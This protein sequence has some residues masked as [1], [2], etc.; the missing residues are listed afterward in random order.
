METNPVAHYHE[1]RTFYDHIEAR[2]EAT[3]EA[4]RDADRDRRHD[5]LCKAVAFAGISAQTAVSKHER[6]YCNAIELGDGYALLGP[7]AIEAGLLEAGVNYYKNKASYI[8]YNAH[9]ADVG[10]ALDA[11]EAHLD[12]DEG[13]LDRMHRAVADEMMGVG[14]RKAGFA[15]A[16][17]V[18]PQ[19]MCIDTHVAQCAGIEPEDV[20]EGVVV[21]RYEAQC[22]QVRAQWPTLDDE[23]DPFMVQWVVFDAHLE[24]LTPHDPWFCS[25]PGEAFQK[26]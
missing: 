7:E 3:H 25:T 14:L 19:K 4:F 12:G 11:Y 9:E 2:L 13:A 16:L 24:A 1:H 17:A 8:W 20:Y 18:S 15:L 26:A 21:E 23:L 10:R 22:E 5:M 6:G